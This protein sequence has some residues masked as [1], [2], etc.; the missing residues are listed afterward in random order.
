MKIPGRVLIYVYDRGA[1]VTFL[2]LNFERKLFFWS[3]NC[4][5]TDEMPNYFFGS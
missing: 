4:T 1:Q 3:A 2:G 5:I